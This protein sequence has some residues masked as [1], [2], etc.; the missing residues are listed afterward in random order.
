L[1]NVF[2]LQY[3]FISFGNPFWLSLL[4]TLRQQ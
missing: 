2:P 1:Y 4:D 3:K